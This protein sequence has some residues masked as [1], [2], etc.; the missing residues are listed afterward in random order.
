MRDPL[1]STTASRAF[2]ASGT[3]WLVD[4]HGVASALLTDVPSLRALLRGAAEEAGARILFDHFH[5]FAHE[6]SAQAGVTGVVLLAESHLTIHTWP[7]T[8]FAAVD[9]FLC[10]KTRPERAVE[11]IERGLAPTTMTVRREQR[12]D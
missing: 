5:D 6:A 2:A 8:G 11:C 7:E 9:L 12:G 10:G 1:T 3:H 4:C